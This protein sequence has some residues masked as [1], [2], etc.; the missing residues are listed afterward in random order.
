MRSEHELRLRRERVGELKVDGRAIGR[1]VDQ[2]RVGE[3]HI[4]PAGKRSDGRIGPLDQPVVADG[5]DLL[6]VV[7]V[8]AEP[9]VRLPTELP[10]RLIEPWNWLMRLNVRLVGVPPWVVPKRVSPWAM[11]LIVRPPGPNA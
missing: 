2:R 4:D 6:E 8:F 11:A 1:Q 3:A 9:P 10:A 7:R 5:L